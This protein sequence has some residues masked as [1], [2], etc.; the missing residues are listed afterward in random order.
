MLT[1]PLGGPAYYPLELVT[2]SYEE[3]A[4]PEL[5]TKVEH[6]TD[7]DGT[8]DSTCVREIENGR[9]TRVTCIEAGADGPLFTWAYFYENGVV[10]QADRDASM[11]TL[12][13]GKPDFRYTWLRD[14]V[15]R[16]TGYQQD[17][18]AS[19]D[20]PFIDGVADFGETYSPGCT[21]LIE[22]FPWIGHLGV[23]EG[24]NPPSAPV[25]WVPR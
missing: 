8:V 23:E 12:A 17:G 22:R 21:P 1:T 18:T 11:W 16:L 7:L 3:P 10:S 14:E 4:S 5:W 13:D 9:P 15:G 20:Q 19:N 25:T 6:D 2:Y 24:I